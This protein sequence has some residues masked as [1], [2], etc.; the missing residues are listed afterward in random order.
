MAWRRHAS[1]VLLSW[2]PLLVFTMIRALRFSDGERAGPWLEYGIPWWLAFTAVALGLGLA[3]RM[4]TFRRERDS[5]KAHAERDALT[6]VLNRGAIEHRL[7]WAL[8]ERQREGIPVS[9]LFID[10]DHFKQ[11]NDRWG[12]L[13]GDEVLR[14]FAKSL[15]RHVRSSDIVARYGGE[16]F[17]VCQQ[18]PRSASRARLEAL[19]E[20]I[21]RAGIETPDGDTLRCTVSIGVAEL[22]A[23]QDLRDLLRVADE[24]L[25]KAKQQGRNR[26]V[27]S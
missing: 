26:L 13:V 24:R 8:I 27:S 23:G 10:L 22:E 1:I 21:A 7:D 12:H 25:Y 16:E 20:G 2:L 5:A 4:L 18:L 14:N 15:M 17:L 3:H 9:L 11:V 6:G 19:R